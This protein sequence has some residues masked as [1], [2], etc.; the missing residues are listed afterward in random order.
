M[1]KRAEFHQ[2]QINVVMRIVDDERSYGTQ[3]AQIN[4]FM[5]SDEEWA[6]AREQIAEALLQV[7]KQV[8]A[9]SD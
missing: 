7:G 6:A 5:N 1:T 8:N 3:Q 9:S 2:A 4:L